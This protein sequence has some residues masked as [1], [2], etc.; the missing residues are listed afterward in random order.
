MT[1]PGSTPETDSGAGSR[2]AS[3]Q[4]TPRGTGIAGLPAPEQRSR[5]DLI[6]VVLIALAL[7]VTIL[8]VWAFSQAGS[9]ERELA[10]QPLSESPQPAG[11]KNDP[12]TI[13]ASVKPLWDRPNTT[14]LLVTAKGGVLAV[15]GRKATMFAAKDG[16]EVWSYT[17]DRDICG[18][19]SDW[20]RIILV[21]RSPKGCG[22]AVSFDASTGQYAHTRDAI[23]AENVDMFTSNSNVGTISPTRIE[24]WRSDLV[25][26]VEV[27]KQEAPPQANQQPN[28]ECAFTSALMR[29]DLLATSQKCPGRDQRLVRL[30]KTT[31]K[32]NDTP[33]K[34]HQFTVPAGAE[35]VAVSKDKAVIYIHGNGVRAAS[36]DDQQGSRF[37]ILSEDGKFSQVPADP[38]RMYGQHQDGA[39]AGEVSYGGSVPG[40]LQPYAADLPH[41][42][43]WW[44][45]ERLI[46]FHPTTLEPLLTVQ[47]AIG[48]GDDMGGR[49]LVPVKN[50]IAVVNWD[51]GQL[52]RTIPVDRAG[53]Q[54]PVVLKVTDGKIVEKRGDTT[55]VLG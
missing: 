17:R 49:A 12:S 8:G 5:R 7:V 45:G 42:I 55:V 20:D 31:P 26:T 32:R 24:L 34:Y 11:S 50:G 46:A 47:G 29:Q 22:E 51:N 23:A 38:S 44:D 4:P 3:A 27:G 9:V 35:V 10:A 41:H 30:L 6:A 52:E 40:V 15:E 37:Q 19:A 43:T 18:A 36:K 39:N 1:N 25:R 54:G 13:P 16:R 48:T 2:P 21:F 14:G 33:E 53:Y 28:T